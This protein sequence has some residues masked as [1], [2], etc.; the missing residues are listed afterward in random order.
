MVRVLAD[1]RSALAEAK[2][3]IAR[4]TLII[5]KLQRHQF[6]RRAECLDDDQLQ[7]GFEDLSADIARVEAR[8]PAEKTASIEPCVRD[9]RLPPL[10]ADCEFRPNW[11][12]GGLQGPPTR[13][14]SQR[15]R[16]SLAPNRG[17]DRWERRWFKA[18]LPRV[19]ETSAVSSRQRAKDRRPAPGPSGEPSCS[20][21][22]PMTAR[23][24]RMA[25]RND[26]SCQA[27]LHSRPK[28]LCKNERYARITL[29]AICRA[30]RVPAHKLKVPAARRAALLTKWNISTEPERTNGKP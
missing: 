12:P 30:G 29:P 15:R 26:L 10:Q 2:A 19:I 14:Y 25:A 16:S 23:G 20:P 17:K 6:G 7:L 27:R 8:L 5:G 11:L 18:G 24:R 28:S 4:L 21:D 9:G 1:E 13:R 3:E 22:T